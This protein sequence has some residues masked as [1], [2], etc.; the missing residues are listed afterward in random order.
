MKHYLDDKLL[1]SPDRINVL[2]IGC[3]GTGSHV[4]SCLARI[5]EALE[6]TGKNGITVTAYDND[7]VE[8][9]NIGRQL[10]YKQDIGRNKAEVII[11]RINATYG[12]GWI[13]YPILFSFKDK[14][15]EHQRWD[16]IITCADKVG[17]RREV[18]SYR[19]LWIYFLDFGNSKDSGQC[20]LAH[21][22]SGMPTIIDMYPDLVDDEDE[23]S[24]SAIESLSKQ[25]LLVNSTLANLGC[26]LLWKL[27]S[28]YYIEYRGLFLNLETGTV[29][30]I[31]I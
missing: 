11:G 30:S 7:T 3:G 13:G 17:I 8:A 20:I 6:M 24:C 15:N 25:S 4:L 18:D 2:V 31:E 16:I 26:N 28:D 12:Y 19:D 23:P 29:K 27:L 5:N 22:K 9:H 1:N 14:H 21:Q 10:F